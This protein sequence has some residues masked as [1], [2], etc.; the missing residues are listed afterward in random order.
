[1]YQHSIGIM[2]AEI[3]RDR[4]YQFQ[5]A[6]Q[7]IPLMDIDTDIIMILFIIRIT[8][9]NIIRGLQNLISGYRISE[10]ITRI[11]YG[12]QDTTKT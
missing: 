12:L 5:S 8:G 2:Y 4:M 9:T 11:G 1:M 3:I 10:T 7:S 6:C